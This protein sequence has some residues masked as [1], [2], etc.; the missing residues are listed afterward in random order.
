MSDSWTKFCLFNILN[1]FLSGQAFSKFVKLGPA[2]L[3]AK[4]K[5]FKHE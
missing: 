4:A 5:E 3:A 2:E 1:Y